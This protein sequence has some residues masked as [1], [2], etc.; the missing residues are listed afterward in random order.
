MNK[1]NILFITHN[2]TNCGVYDFGERV[3]ETLKTSKKFTFIKITCDNINDLNAAINEYAPVTI[4]YNYTIATLSWV[5]KKICRGIYYNNISYIK[6]PQIG[7][8]HEITQQLAD[9]A[10]QKKRFCI[11]KINKL[12]NSL[13]DSYIA[14]DPTLLLKNPLVYKTGRIIPKYI[15]E[16]PVSANLVITSFGFGTAKKG[17]SN[18]VNKIQEEFDTAEIRI[19]IPF[20][21]YGDKNGEEAKKYAIKCKELLHKPGIKLNITHNYFDQKQLLDFLAQSSLIAFF[22]ED[23]IGRGISSVIDYALAVNRPIAISDSIMFRHILDTEP[24]ICINDVSLKQII[25]NRVT[26]LKK[27]AE[28]W[29]HENLLWEYERIINSVL[30]RE[31]YLIKDS[32]FYLLKSFIKKIIDKYSDNYIEHYNWLRKTDKLYDDDYKNIISNYKYTGCILPDKFSLNRILDNEAREVYKPAIKSLFEL[33]PNT[34]AKKIPMA[35]VNQGFIFDTVYRFIKKYNNPKILCIGSYEDTACMALIK[36]GYQVEEIDPMV[37]Y[38][39]QEFFSKPN[40]LKHNY[41]IIFSTSVIEHDNDDKSFI[42]SVDKLL[43]PNGVFIMTCDYKDN[44]K[45]NDPKPSVC[46]RFYTKEDLMFRLPSYMT[47]CEFITVPNWTYIK[48]DF[49]FDIYEYTFASFVIKKKSNIIL[50]YYE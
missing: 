33:V 16:F 44:W 17:F 13:F 50:N 24:S 14:A 6:I 7:I 1:N 20:A 47:N 11:T 30:K 22:Y 29:T 41:D 9:T 40:T 5:I 2:K 49:K 39:L 8:I 21:E 43:T 27:F 37:N 45:K 4:I 3:F 35:N 23:K 26:P 34:M 38:T 36:L 18:L 42:E 32:F 25:S 28:E 31:V 10:S 12:D 46:A 15:N 19:N 48:P